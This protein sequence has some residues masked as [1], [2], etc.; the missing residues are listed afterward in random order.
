MRNVLITG[1][2]LWVVGMGGCIYIVGFTQS[3]SHPANVLP[4]LIVTGISLSGL[5]LSIVGGLYYLVQDWKG[6]REG[7][8]SCGHN[9]TANTT[10]ICPECGERI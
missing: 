8:C 6:K 2:I 5:I 3:D 9:L 4:L 10:G 7:F 1:A